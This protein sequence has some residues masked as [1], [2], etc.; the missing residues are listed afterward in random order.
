MYVRFAYNILY[1]DKGER[2]R[3]VGF[4]DNIKAIPI[5]DLAGRMNYTLVRKGRYYSLKEHD[6]VIIDTQKNCFWRNSRFSKGF[7]GGAGSSID[8]MME[9]GGE[10]DYKSA[11]RRLAL[12]YGIEGDKPPQTAYRKIETPQA[13]LQAAKKEK[14]I[15]P[16]KVDLP[17][18]SGR[19][20]D[21]FRY[22][23]GRG[24]SASVIKYFLARKM[25]YEDVRKNCVFVSPTMDFA[26]VRSTGEQRFIG[27]C[28]GSNYDECFFFK[29]RADAKKLIVAESVIDI[30]SIMTY[31]QM[32]GKW[33]G[34]YAYLALAGTNKVH[35]LFVHLSRE[36]QVREVILCFDRDEAGEKANENAIKGMKEMGFSG[37]W[38]I[39]KPPSG[40]DWN[41]YI[42]TLM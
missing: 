42:R 39:E 2:G 3:N 9:F 26:C 18:K 19:N 11:M 38:K 4:L 20:N 15:F 40:K 17:K 34:N 22:L 6:S 13:K 23:M 8:F 1:A 27:D 31:I 37:V 29:G 32:Q 21:V 35:S 14:R 16:G 36:S 24:I 10:P 25:L 33:Y 30:M 12:M 28:E 7:K 5:T 41:D